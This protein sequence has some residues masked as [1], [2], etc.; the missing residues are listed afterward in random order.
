MEIDGPDPV[1]EAVGETP[2]SPYRSIVDAAL[3]SM[4]A[5]ASTTPQTL[6]RLR[7]LLARTTPPSPDELSQALAEPEPEP[8]TTCDEGTGANESADH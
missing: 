3:A 4:T 7:T 8:A 2:P 6:R 5:D 1:V